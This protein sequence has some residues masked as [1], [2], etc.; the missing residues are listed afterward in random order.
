MWSFLTEGNPLLRGLLFLG[1][2]WGAATAMY[3]AVEPALPGDGYEYLLTVQALESHFSPRITPADR[4]EIDALLRAH[5]IELPDR[6]HG[7]VALDQGSVVSWHFWLYPL[8]NLPAKRILYLC[9]AN[10]LACF[11]VTNAAVACLAV[12]WVYW[13]F[14]GAPLRSLFCIL[15]PCISPILWYLPWPAPEVWLFF[16]SMVALALLAFGSRAAILL[17]SLAA[18]QSPPF[19][20]PLLAAVAVSLHGGKIPL[21]KCAALTSPVV[22]APLTSLYYFGVLNPILSKGI[23]WGTVSMARTMSFF[24]DLD[25]GLIAY[26]PGCIILIALAAHAA[27]REG[28][29]RHYVFLFALASFIVSIQLTK[30]WN[31]GSAGLMRYAVW[32]LPLVT[33]LFSLSLPDTPWSWRLGISMVIGHG[34]ILLAYGMPPYYLNHTPLARAVL[35]HIPVIYYAVPEVF[36]E[37][38]AGLEFAWRRE[39][40]IVH[41]DLDGQVTKL[42]VGEKLTKLMAAYQ[43]EPDCLEE[44]R[45]SLP[46]ND[47]A[48]FITPPRGCVTLR[49]EAACGLRDVQRNLKLRWPNRT[50]RVSRPTLAFAARL[51]NEARCSF[52]SRMSGS[53]TNL[54]LRYSILGPEGER[55]ESGTAGELIHPLV[56]GG[57]STLRCRVRLPLRPGRFT[58]V[59]KPQLGPTEVSTQAQTLELV[60]ER[61][62]SL[63]YAATARLSGSAG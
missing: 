54:A 13:L 62:V 1:L 51:R 14:S 3:H 22:L 28:S 30:N 38:E 10:Q 49:M 33:Y 32:V 18:A 63:G 34:I 59:L 4:G 31:H 50:L 16:T 6:V 24:F 20:F 45:R 7:L 58:I 60:V 8:L 37:R 43:I 12:L 48:A 52:Y 5:G 26:T 15:V 57:R 41:L 2:P 40:P 29:A 35:N 11:Q 27:L 46:S 17:L 44:L 19:V 25:Q 39:L 47:R 21:W 36:A 9:G 55:F 42:L 23:D 53:K 61:G 56:A